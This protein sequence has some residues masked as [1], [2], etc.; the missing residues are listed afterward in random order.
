MAKLDQITI[1]G[2]TYEMVP[3]IAPLFD[4][5]KAYAAGDCVIKDAA[6][7]R[8]VSAHAAG[9]WVGTDAEEVTVGDEL[10]N[11]KADFSEFTTAVNDSLTYV[12][13]TNFADRIESPMQVF[14][15]A[16]ARLGII[17]FSDVVPY[18][19]KFITSNGSDTFGFYNPFYGFTFGIASINGGVFS[20]TSI[21]SGESG[22]VLDGIE[23]ITGVE[24]GFYK[25]YI[26]NLPKATYILF[27]YRK[28]DSG[29]IKIHSNNHYTMPGVELDSIQDHFLRYS[30]REANTSAG[31][32]MIKLENKLV[33]TTNGAI[34]T[35]E[36]YDTYY[37]MSQVSAL[38]VTCKNGFR[39]VITTKDPTTIT[40]NGYLASVVYANAS[41]RVETF[42]LSLGQYAVISV[43][44][45][46]G[47]IN[48]VT[49]YVKTFTLP[50]LRLSYQQKNGFYRLA[51][52]GSATYLY[53]YMVSGEKVVQ[54]ELHNVPATASNSNT[55]Q[56]GH[57]MGYDYDGQSLSNGVEL[58]GG[59]EFELAFKEYGSADYCGG[60][61]HGDE[62]TIDFVLMIDGET[63][64]LTNIDADYHAFNRI[65]AFEQAYVN[66]CDTP[67]ENILKHQKI[68]TFENGTAKVRQTLE[69]LESLE[70]DFL[71]CMLAANRSAFTHGVRQGRVGIEDMS[72]ATYDKVYTRGNEMMYLMYGTNATAKITARTADHTPEC[73]LWIN[74]ASA[75]NKLYYNYF[76]QMPRTAVESGTVLK[77]EQE[78]DIAYN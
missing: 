21:P 78:Y 75:L 48:L 69:F 40:S 52:S 76:G 32:S 47:D 27:A 42:S 30:E 7:Y 70:C 38:N 10:T 61:N 54:W 4:A 1:N 62:N 28:V 60:N 36:S 25:K 19:G 71:C 77:W 35:N 5:T 66:R 53:M 59:G 56:I 58:V 72:T 73:T 3:E 37:F 45:T 16:D 67:T 17:K 46:A 51:K 9:A 29:N 50:T 8:F 22:E 68:W 43:A 20:V 31:I 39:A 26:V 11:L 24:D 74:N 41:A 33:N 18:N 63:V 13:N 44:H 12:E 6:L 64:D 15:F 49:D 14:Q 55:W 23:E 57:V 34:S 65:D 2:T